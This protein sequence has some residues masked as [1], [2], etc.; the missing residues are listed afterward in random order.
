[1]PYE[2]ATLGKGCEASE[3][4]GIYDLASDETD[5]KQGPHSDPARWNNLELIWG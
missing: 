4:N 5:P 2:W 3:M 1:M